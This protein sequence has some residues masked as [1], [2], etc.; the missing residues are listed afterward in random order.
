MIHA[1]LA[2]EHLECV[3]EAQDAFLDARLQLL[4]GNTQQL[5]LGYGTL[6]FLHDYCHLSTC[7][8]KETGGVFSKI[9]GANTGFLFW[10]RIQIKEIASTVSR[11]LFSKIHADENFLVECIACAWKYAKDMSGN[12]GINTGYEFQLAFEPFLSGYLQR[13]SQQYLRM[14]AF[15][16]DNGDYDVHEEFCEY[17][18]QL[19]VLGKVLNNSIN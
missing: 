2:L 16:L 10:L 7:L 15:K 3:E 14:L 12:I 17:H 9:F 5:K 13:C 19:N 18:K 1:K 6:A 8:L 11:I 4:H